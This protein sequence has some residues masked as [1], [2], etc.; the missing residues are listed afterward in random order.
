MGKLSNHYEKCELLNLGYGP[1]GRGPFLIRQD[2]YLPASESLKEDRFLLRKDGTWVLNLAV[3]VLPEKEKEQFLYESRAEAVKMLQG[4]PFDPVAE[5]SL[6]ADKSRAELA[7]AAESAISGMW[8]R[9]RAAKA[10]RI[11][12]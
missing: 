5:D 10:S 6:P 7:R 11:A 12:P 2:A 8:G 4:L 9:I 1:K 3:F